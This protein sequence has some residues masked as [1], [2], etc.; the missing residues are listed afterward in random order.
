MYYVIDITIH[1]TTGHYVELTH[2]RK[3]TYHIEDVICIM[4]DP[5]EEVMRDRRE[6]VPDVHH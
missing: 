5:W 4:N 3:N 1:S 2:T 6:S